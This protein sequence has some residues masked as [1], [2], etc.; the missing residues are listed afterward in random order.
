MIS[1]FKK[2]EPEVYMNWDEF[3]QKSTFLHTFFIQQ[4]IRRENIKNSRLNDNL[5][6]Q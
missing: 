2:K 3:E 4:Q 6:I 1:W 5:F